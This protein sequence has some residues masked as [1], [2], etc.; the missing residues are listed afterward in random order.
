MLMLYKFTVNFEALRDTEHR[1]IWQIYLFSIFQKARETE[2]YRY[3]KG[4]H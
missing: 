4:I 3:G 1:A 2:T